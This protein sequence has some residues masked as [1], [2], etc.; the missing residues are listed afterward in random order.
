MGNNE[1]GLLVE[2][3]SD[4]AFVQFERDSRDKHTNGNFSGFRGIEVLEEIVHSLSPCFVVFL[5]IR[6]F[7][8]CSPGLT[9]VGFNIRHCM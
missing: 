7:L 4:D 9:A 5:M 1:E 8:S 3:R 2:I 6:R